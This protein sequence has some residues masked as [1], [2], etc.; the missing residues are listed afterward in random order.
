MEQLDWQKR[1]LRKGINCKVDKLDHEQPT[2]MF[3][4]GQVQ[5]QSFGYNEFL[6]PACYYPVFK[7]ATNCVQ[8]Q[9]GLIQVFCLQAK[10]AKAG[11]AP[12][13]K[14]QSA[15]NIAYNRKCLTGSP[16]I[17]SLITGFACPTRDQL[18]L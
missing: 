18:R 13:L 12:S 8:D 15:E 4:T 1:L 2:T 16:R 17:R 14:S 3:H 11:D 9:E 6:H 5:N 7:C 10:T